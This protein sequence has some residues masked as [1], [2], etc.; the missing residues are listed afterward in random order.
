[1]AHE[2]RWSPEAVEDV[3]QIASYIERDS[4]WYAQAVVARFFAAAESLRELPERGRVVPELRDTS[5]RECFV[6]SYRLIYKV[7][8][9]KVLVLAVTHG[10]R[11]LEPLL[12]RMGGEI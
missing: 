8:L 12:S 11:L 2:L 9:G 3:E 6:Y 1:M 5:V 7:S 4:A 10:H